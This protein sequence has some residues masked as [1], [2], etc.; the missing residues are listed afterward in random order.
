[1]V[2]VY[3]NPVMWSWGLI[4]CRGGGRRVFGNGILVK[5]KQFETVPVFNHICTDKIVS[6]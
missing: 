6:I 1:M 4:V 3:K 2:K 5:L